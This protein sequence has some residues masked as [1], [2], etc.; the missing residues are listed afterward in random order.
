MLREAWT[1]AI[2][3]LSWIELHSLSERLALAETAKQLK[4]Q[5]P[6]VVG[7]AHRLV[8]ETL[9]RQNLLDFIINKALAPQTLGE[10][11]LGVQA[12]LRLFTYETRVA[13]N[14]FEKAGSIARLGRSILGWRK[15]RDV[16]EPLG[17]ILNIRVEVLLKEMSDEERVALS[18]FNPLWFVKYCF[19]LLGRSEALEFLQRAAWPSPVYLRINTLRASEENILR[20]LEK[21]G[22]RIERVSKLSYT[23]RL[24]DVEKPLIRT[25]SFREGLFYIQDMASCLAAEIANPEPGATVLDVCAAPGAKTSY[26]AQLMQNQG[27]IF[28]VDYSKRRMNVWRRQMKRM[29]VKIAVPVLADACRPLPL[30]LSA[31]L[32][33][34]DP[35]CTSTGAFGK[36]PSAKWR[37]TKRSVLHMAQIQWKMLQQCAEHVKE[38]GHLIYS[39]CS[40]MLEENETLIERFLKWHPEFTL[41][42]T[43]PRVGLPGLRG[44]TKCQRLY[45]HLH[46]CNGF[47][48]AKLLKIG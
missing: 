14:G 8:F 25:R 34:L 5:D 32:V 39:T 40:I 33:V 48:I 17:R 43:K 38:G 7:L 29:G 9:R 11:E 37:L 15:L 10:L 42:E 19:R 45:P 31:E 27:R 4:I 24:L 23:Y 26:M 44:Q 2:E 36:T 21:E 20:K 35:S 28:S 6:K 16:E 46:N 12:F 22:V 3:T 18:T 41:A 30:R 1:L 13:D 47:F